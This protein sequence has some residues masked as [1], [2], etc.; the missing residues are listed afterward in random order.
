MRE[1]HRITDSDPCG[2]PS[3]STATTL[4]DHAGLARAEMLRSACGNVL[5]E[6]LAQFSAPTGLIN[7][8]DA[9]A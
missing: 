1:S 8:Y 5:T 9:A 7:Q 2:P 4:T 3:R 6:A